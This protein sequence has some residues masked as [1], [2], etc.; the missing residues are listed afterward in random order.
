[1]CVQI[2]AFFFTGKQNAKTGRTIGLKEMEAAKESDD[3]QSEEEDKDDDD[4]GD[5]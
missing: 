5:E 2:H 4:D 1:M 3:E